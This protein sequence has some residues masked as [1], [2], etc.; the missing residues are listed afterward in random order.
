M[1]AEQKVAIVTGGGR[2][3]GAAAAQRLAA[4]GI[5]VAVVARHEAET[6]QVAAG[7]E[8]SG[9]RALALTADVAQEGA[10]EH[11][12]EVVAGHFG[13]PCQILV[14]AAGISGPVAELA[15]VDMASFRQVMEINL[16]G[17]WRL[18]RSVLPAMKQSAWGRIVNIT[19][20]LA[21]RIQPGLGAYSTAKAALSHLSQIMDAEIRQH[22]V[23]V[24]ALEPGVVDSRM[25]GHL[26][27]LEPT[28][29][30]AGIIKM[31]H[32][33]ERDPGLVQEAESARL[34]HLAATGQADD[35][36]GTAF[37][38]YDPAIRARIA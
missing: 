8:A 24:F 34:I 13:Q 15:E 28:G 30:R 11:I 25:T 31:L 21:R 10:A 37:S 14:N 22:G 35:L 20:G 27:S 9:G 1:Q 19:S 2:G 26:R 4:D 5:A 7:I 18:A 23:R 33:M 32:D 29:I 17:A 12:T 38:I 3:I 6:A 36:A 16:L